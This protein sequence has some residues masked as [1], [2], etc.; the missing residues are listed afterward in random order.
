MSWRKEQHFI[1]IA[2]EEHVVLRIDNWPSSTR[3]E[4][5]GVTYLFKWIE[6]AYIQTAR[7]FRVVREGNLDLE[8][9]KVK[10]HSGYIW[11][12]KVVELAKLASTSP[13]TQFNLAHDDINFLSTIDN[14]RNMM[15]FFNDAQWSQLSCNQDALLD[16]IKD[17][18]WDVTW[19]AM[20]QVK[21][22]K[23]TKDETVA[24]IDSFTGYRAIEVKAAIFTVPAYHTT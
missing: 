24:H 5:T 14:I 20:K 1:E 21:H 22:F 16:R 12:E 18:D 4:I 8:L 23:C 17:Y 9:H 13:S 15:Q 2:T 6:S 7:I 10:G 19:N 11:N 3:A